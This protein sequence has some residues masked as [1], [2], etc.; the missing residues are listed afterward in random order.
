M[1][2]IVFVLCLTHILCHLSL[3][4]GLNKLT[5][6]YQNVRGLRTKTM[7][8]YN[9][10]LLNNFDIYVI[11]ETWLHP[12]IF[13]AELTDSRYDIFRLDRD[14]V[15]SGSTMGGGVMVCVRRELRAKSMKSDNNQP[16]NATELLWVSIPA[17]SLYTSSDLHIAVSYVPPNYRTLPSNINNIIDSVI[18]VQNEHTNDNFLILG[19]FNL[20]NIERTKLGPI[21]QKK[22]CVEVQNA[23]IRMIDEF[24][25]LGL[26]Q[27]NTNCNASGN[28]LDLAFSDLLLIIDKCDHPL[29]QEDLAHPSLLIEFPDLCV[30]SLKEKSSSKFL[31]HKGD[32]EKINSYLSQI[33][34]SELLSACVDINCAVN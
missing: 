1:Y 19:D 9:G 13:D 5:V 17:I 25:C 24:C 29:V 15:L 10:L 6:Y 22:G 28:I 21:H 8:F 11:T 3:K 18:R 33:N 16:A 14:P 4:E 30:S 20:P 32:Y 7:D 12:G 34:W 26:E 27:Y 23:G 31:F 2:Q